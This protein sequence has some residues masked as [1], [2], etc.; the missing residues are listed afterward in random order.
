MFGS[1]QKAFADTCFLIFFI[2]MSASVGYAKISH[3]SHSDA[4]KKLDIA[5]IMG[6]C[7]II[8]A[9]IYKLFDALS[10]VAKIFKVISLNI[11]GLVILPIL[12]FLCAA[13]DL[14]MYSVVYDKDLR[15]LFG[16]EFG[17]TW[18]SLTFIATFFSLLAM[19]FSIMYF[20]RPVKK[21]LLN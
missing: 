5:T 11:F 21:G 13:V 15:G 7:S 8:L 2:F 18:F 20:K 3:V 6:I 17:D 14:I 4:L 1:N 10:P 12:S 19:I 16:S 9:G